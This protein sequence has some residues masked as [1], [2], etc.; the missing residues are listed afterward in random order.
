MVAAK[1]LGWVV[2]GRGGWLAIVGPADGQATV[3]GPDLVLSATEHPS[4]STF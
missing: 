1:A 2:Y 3:K 4:C